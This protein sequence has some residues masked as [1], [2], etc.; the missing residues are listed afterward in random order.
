MP[1]WRACRLLRKADT[2]HDGVLTM[3]ELDTIVDFA[4]ARSSLIK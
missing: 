2:N 4:L 1:G 3:E